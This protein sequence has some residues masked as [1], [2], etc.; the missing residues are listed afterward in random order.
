MTLDVEQV[1][2]FLDGRGSEKMLHEDNIKDVEKS[3]SV[4]M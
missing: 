2:D 3:I 1:S 4:R